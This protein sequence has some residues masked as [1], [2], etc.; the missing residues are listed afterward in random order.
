MPEQL[1]FEQVL[2]DR[3]A[4]DRD[5]RAAL[6]GRS[7]RAGPRASSSLPVPLA[8]SSMTET[9]VLATR[10]IVRATRTISGAA[11][12]SPPSTRLPSPA[13]SASAR[14]SASMRC[15]LKRAADDQA[16]L[17][18]V[19]RL[20]VEIVGARARSPSAR[21]RA[22]RGREA[23]ITLV[24]GFSA[25]ISSSTAKP[26]LVPSG[27]GG[28]PRSSV[29]TAGSS[30]RSAAMRAGAVAGDDHLE[31]VVGPL[32]L[33]LQPLVVLDDQQLGFALGHHATSVLL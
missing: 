12:I 27:S 6:R 22:R 32:E 2:G 25:M 23:T 13:R 29:T 9:L 33:R 20:L 14:F 19:D 7:P 11:V 21:F 30:A 10:S 15:R 26:S 18:D 4:V 1:A 17:L 5:E 16:E 28:R 8:P 31:I 3:R 24:S